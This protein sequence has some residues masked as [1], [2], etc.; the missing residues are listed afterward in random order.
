MTTLLFAGTRD[1]EWKKVDQA[2]SQGQPRTAITNLE[3]IIA[4]ALREKAYAEA[5]K[6]IGKKIVLEANIQGNKPEEKITRLEAEIRK[7]P[8]EM[9]PVLDTLLAHWY[10]QYFQQNRWRFM[11]RT[12]TAEAPGKDFTTWD[13]RRLFAEIDGQFQKALSAAAVLRRTP[14]SAWNDLLTKGTL[15][16]TYRP[17]LYDF[18]AH[19]ALEFYTSGEQAAA[20]PQDDFEL[21][22]TSPIFQSV[23]AFLA[24]T[25]AVAAGS[26]E[27]PTLRAVRL[28]QDLLRFH[29]N[30]P[31]PGAALADADLERLVWGWRASFGEDKNAQYKA[32]LER[33]IA[34]HGNSEICA[35]ALEHEAQLVQQDG[36]LVTARTL[37]IR[38][39]E[40]FPESVGGKLCRNLKDQI[41]AK[42]A[43]ISTERVWTCF[44]GSGEGLPKS[45]ADPASTN[46]QNCA[47]ISIR[48]R[49]VEAVYFRAIPYD[50][51]VFLERR[52]NRP[53]NLNDAER[54]EI[55]QQTPALEWSEQLPATPDFKERTRVFP[56]P[57]KLKPGFYFIVASHRP[58]FG[59]TQNVV[60][61]APVWVTD[62]ALVTRTRN[63]Q[64]EGF[65]L[66]ANSGEPVPNAE[67]SVWHL[68][69]NRNRVADPSLKTDENGFFTFKSSAN[70]GFLFR[71]RFNG[72]EIASATDLWFYG[73]PVDSENR[74]M[75]QTIFFTDR[76]L[77]RPGQ[78]IQFKGICLWVDQQKAN[79]EVLK[80]ETETVIFADGNGKE[81]SRLKVQANE[82]G[83]FSGSF[84]APRDRLMGRAT[85]QVEGRATGSAWVQIE[86]YKRP[87]FQVTLD[88][89]K[90]PAKLDET[91][92]L[93]G[94]AMTYAGAPVDS[95]PVRFHVVREAR[96]P[97]WWGWYSRPWRGSGSHEIAHGV[98]TTGVDGSF[99]IQFNAK[100]DPNVPAQDEP[101]FVFQV[102]AD[103][104]DSAGETRSAGQS[105]QVGYT[106]LEATLGASDWQTTAAPVEVL[107][108]TRSLDGQPQVAEGRV[109]V[110]DLQ[111]PARA[112]P[113]PLNGSVLF[114]GRDLSGQV[115]GDEPNQDLSNPNNWSLGRV[116][117]ET[118]FTTDTNGQARVSFKLGVGAFRAIVETQDR[119]G[120]KVSGKMPIRVIDPDATH[121]A[122]RI[123]QLL[124]A[125]QWEISPGRDFT[126]V[127]GT[128]YESGRAFI[129]IEHRHQMV[130]R[131]WTR[132][133]QTEQQ[134]KIAV[135]DAMRGGFTLHITQ[136]RED[137]VYLESRPVSVPWSNK[138]L[139][140]HWEH[141]V[142]KLEPGRKESWTA[143]IAKRN[144]A[145]GVT[146]SVEQ[147][148][149][150]MV[151][152]LYD[153]SLDA[154]MPFA[155][156]QRFTIFRRD[157]ST[158]QEQ[159]ANAQVAFQFVLGNWGTPYQG[160]QAS[161]RSFPRDLTS[162]VW[163][164]AFPTARS[165]GG[166]ALASAKLADSGMET[167]RQ[168]LSLLPA[169][170][171]EASVVAGRT[172]MDAASAGVAYNEGEHLPGARGGTNVK[173]DGVAA[174]K[175]L[176]ETA[177]FFPQLTT[178]TNG[179]VR[180][181]F[182][183]PEALTKWHFMA[184][185][186][187][188]QACS[189][190]LED[191]AVTAKDLM[192]QPNPPRFLREGDL[193]EFT[194]K[195]SN[196]S[197]AVQVG[198]V[199]LSFA[200]AL[201]GQPADKLL[202]LVS[203]SD[204]STS[205]L[206]QASSNEQAFSIPARQSRGF[207]W[208]ISVPDGCGFLSYKAVAASATVSD[209]EEGAIPVLSR[210]ILVT[211][212]LPLSIRGPSTKKFELADLIKSG[213]SKSIQNKS[214]TVQ[215]VSNPAWYAVLALPYLM[216]YPHECSEQTFNRIYAN[217]LAKTVAASDPKI[218]RVFEQWR[219]TPALDSPLEK[220]QDLKSV[221]L[222]E[223]PWLKQALSESQAR[224]N[225]GILFD[226]N[227]LNYEIGHTME[228]LA[229]MQLSDGAWPWF[230]G[231]QAN[232]F[233]TL[234]ITT[235]FGRL[236]HLGADVDMTA[237]IRS[238]ARLDAWMNENYERIQKLNEPDKY[239]PSPTDALYL[240]GR[241]FF[242]T[243]KPIA[244]GHR[245][246]VEFFLAQSRKFWLR[247]DCR[248]TQGQLALALSR[249][250]VASGAHDTTPQEILRS[251]KE[252]SV[253]NEEMGMFWRETELSWW[254]YRAPIETQALMIEAFDEVLHD[255]AAVE[256]CKVWLLKQ[257]QTQ[258]W[259]TTKATADAVYALLLRGRDLLLSD[260]LVRVKLD[261]IEIT[262]GNEKSNAKRSATT[263]EPGTGFYEARF[264]GGEIKAR[265]G[266]ISVQKSDPGIAWGSVHWQYLEDISKVT[267]YQG[268]PLKLTKSLFIK[269]ATNRGPVLEPVKGALK[270]GD[271]LV[272]RIELRVDRD[273]E[274]VHMKDQRGSGTEPVNVLSQYKYQD[275]LG[276]Y[277]STR[278]TATH[279][280][281]DYLRK[282]TYVFEYST[283]VQLRGH[284]P[285]GVAEIECMYAPEF[286]SHSGS[287]ELTVK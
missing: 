144:E 145:S 8:P 186:H 88:T 141:F 233:I 99:K 111:A 98:V 112:Q 132:P 198:S 18:L 25:P 162:S 220:N 160:V 58:D 120:K 268:T 191:H 225:V 232:D 174:R 197:D 231:G 222:E 85:L 151:A 100:P 34:E 254:W 107:V 44:E 35:M 33:F 73:N 71:A 135:T 286:A 134:I 238:L 55:L 59:P 50:W 285:T 272:V 248:Q 95:A 178:D 219:N 15:P 26:E 119:Y 155:W 211:E 172:V 62:L 204:P 280:F 260:T 239:V 127:W 201:T 66:A 242:L 64:F 182:S 43:A 154:F 63:G 240:Y 279:F 175:N 51:N 130:Q 131:Y 190:F 137:R 241:S 223:T 36:D 284:Y 199:R 4:A 65:V 194:V 9:V 171:Q 159:F 82:F 2:V 207:S 249:F 16:D 210:R 38:G 234:Y 245:K 48:Y 273:M 236:R 136:V 235:G 117:A 7:A 115:T 54:R 271:E 246:A 206:A 30:D 126:A 181:T 275:G 262:P 209:G 57:A 158:I 41:E 166:M 133:N 93:V 29:L 86:E 152:T 203:T 274:Y 224:K 193:I 81:I 169:A 153:E 23:P 94:H 56:S 10:W 237:A 6:A 252:R 17:T 83:S 11:Q 3:P 139:D 258:D 92:T 22:S 114:F 176:N 102:N 170:P 122:I 212:S 21:S 217:A 124:A 208:R 157:Y 37:A 89:P 213:G 113:A 27:S 84:I 49:N 39:V 69:Q 269:T 116:V 129:E 42:S 12:A 261:G 216:E 77:Y 150:E 278:D 105:V 177:F 60:S 128:G 138:E 218:H 72:H 164:F 78:T 118:G 52:H 243:D 103:V 180:L 91:V 19:E 257:K 5:V 187:N 256:E 185:A 147:K 227:R 70:G 259:K 68:D 46:A 156:Q 229:Q 123:P 61:F 221:A 287:I 179:S 161:Y 263:P 281:F 31:A 97:W 173:L 214:L 76:G 244:G 168:M 283:R 101:T 226:D 163:G 20:K 270:P 200:D 205:S 251:I 40:Q 267:S 121:L 276:Y 148:A 75:A 80:G 165:L 79:Y 32:A 250:S 202:G 230:P 53:E 96:T 125:P 282:G 67:V 110:Y 90:V 266:N 184:F 108:T 143:V 277:E 253:T 28:Y 183:M 104:T 192:V 47:L 14:I 140:L 265:M 142:S 247:T 13:L 189:G 109:L 167:H 1:T 264:S 146:N 149:A 188:A 106:A 255:Q 87:K 74:P 45:P 228:K 196:Q 215:M 24:W 195:V